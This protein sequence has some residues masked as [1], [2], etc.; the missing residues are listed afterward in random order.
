M[1]Q[2]IS[3]ITILRVSQIDFFTYR[4]HVVT[5]PYYCIG[6]SIASTYANMYA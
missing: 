3:K 4:S 1:I 5:H 6:K 2:L